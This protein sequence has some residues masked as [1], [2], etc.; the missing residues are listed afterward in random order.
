MLVKTDKEVAR[1]LGTRLR[2]WRI[3]KRMS[4]A[5]V[6]E[7]AGIHENTLRSLEHTGEAKLIT[8]ISVLRA[9]GERAGLEGLLE[10]EP[11][12]DLF[13]DQP[14]TPVQRVRERRS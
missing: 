8:V 7:R 1:E 10:G 12:R 9:L 14:S 13:A 5:T 4:Q 2:R 3:A 6:A 11:P